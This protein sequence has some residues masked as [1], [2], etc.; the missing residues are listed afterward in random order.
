MCWHFN[1]QDTREHRNNINALQRVQ[2]KQLEEVPQAIFTWRTQTSGKQSATRHS[3]FFQKSPAWAYL[4]ADNKK[5]EKDFSKDVDDLLP[6]AAT[7]I[8]VQFGLLE[9]LTGPDLL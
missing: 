9:N 3:G 8:K 4:M 1:T 7:L 5:Q 6:L 2:V